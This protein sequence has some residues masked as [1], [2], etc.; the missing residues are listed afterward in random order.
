MKRI[1]FLLSL[2]AVCFEIQAITDLFTRLMKQESIAVERNKQQDAS[3]ILIQT[4]KNDPNMFTRFLKELLT[5]PCLLLVDEGVNSALAEQLLPGVTMYE[6]GED[7][8]LRTEHFIKAQQG[9]CV[10][11]NALSSENNA[12]QQVIQEQKLCYLPVRDLFATLNDAESSN[13]D[14]HK[15][16]KLMKRKIHVVCTAAIIPIKVEERRDQYVR[17]LSRVVEFGY[18]PYIVESCVTGPTYLDDWSKHVLYTQTNDTSLNNKGVN[19]FTSMLHAFNTWNFND[20]DIV[21]KLTG[22]YFFQTD[23]FIRFLED[24]DDIDCAAKFVTV[25]AGLPTEVDAVL[26]GCFAMRFGL[27]KQMLNFFDYDELEREMLCVEH[28]VGP[29]LNKLTENGVTVARRDMLHVEANMFYSH[30]SSEISYW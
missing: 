30:G 8:S 5:H 3:K 23:E 17:A 9:Y 2:G 21:V 20:D 18:H 27:F 13:I 6:D 22:R 24:A 29:Y 11:L 19:E 26:T 10:I 15:I 16:F 14:M 28:V 25:A 4:A 1:F 7:L 12:L